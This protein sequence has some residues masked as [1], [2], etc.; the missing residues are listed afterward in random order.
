MAR[1]LFNF[2]N[3]YLVEKICGFY[4]FDRQDKGLDSLSKKKKK[5]RGLTW[6]CEDEGKQ[7]NG[8]HSR[9]V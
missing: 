4:D 9:V 1:V 7:S 8:W 2:F 5:I 3:G 6:D